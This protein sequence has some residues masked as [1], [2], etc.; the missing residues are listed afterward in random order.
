MTTTGFLL[1]GEIRVD[2]AWAKTEQGNFETPLALQKLYQPKEWLWSNSFFSLS[3]PE[4]FFSFSGHLPDLY[5][6][7]FICKGYCPP[8]L[9]RLLY[10][11]ATSPKP[12]NL[13][14][15]PVVIGIDFGK[16]ILRISMF[17][18]RDVLNLNPLGNRYHILRLLVCLC[19]K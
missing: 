17:T 6:C 5:C 16:K 18:T 1:C 13:K 3:N 7:C 2:Y 12:F 9:H 4:P 19:A 11:S 14:D 8:S 15:Y 10:M